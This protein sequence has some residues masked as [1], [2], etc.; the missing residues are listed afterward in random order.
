MQGEK[1][2]RYVSSNLRGFVDIITLIMLIESIHILYDFYHLSCLTLKWKATL[3]YL[4]MN[5]YIGPNIS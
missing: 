3:A 1:L 2:K 5:W 4:T